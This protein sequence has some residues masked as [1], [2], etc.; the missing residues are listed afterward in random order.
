MDINISIEKMQS[1]F[2]RLLPHNGFCNP[3]YKVIVALQPLSHDQKVLKTVSMPLGFGGWW[4]H[5]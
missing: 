2:D 3:I 4:L 5:L 1:L